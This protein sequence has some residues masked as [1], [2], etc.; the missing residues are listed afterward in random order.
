MP[1]DI[2][3]YQLD[4]ILVKQR[5]RNSVKNSRSFPGADIDSDH[6][7]VMMKAAV[8]LK[9]LQTAKRTKKW[10]LEGIK[11]KAND[12]NREMVQ[13]LKQ[14]DGVVNQVV[15]VNDKWKEF[16]KAIVKSAET[17]I[18]YKTTRKIKKPWISQMMISKMDEEGNGS[19]YAQKRQQRT[20][21]E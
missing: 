7:L 13:N 2:G 1:G 3:R 19:A 4:Y 21:R 20:T 6:N 10:M 11:E 18:G 8:R 12:F 15:N 14:A 5:Y 9:K 16:S 17:T